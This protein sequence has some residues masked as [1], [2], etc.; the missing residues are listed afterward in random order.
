MSLQD[1]LLDL[2][3]AIGADVKA[4]KTMF[5]SPVAGL[6]G[7]LVP[8]TNAI[9]HTGGAFGTNTISFCLFDVGPVA[10]TYDALACN[11]SSTASTGTGVSYRGGVYYD[12]GTNGKP[13]ALLVDA[14]EFGVSN[15][16]I[17]V[18]TTG[19]PITLQPGRYWLGFKSSH[20]TAP[21]PVPQAFQ[22]ASAV[23]LPS[24]G[25]ATA[26]TSGYKGWTGS[27]ITTGAMPS[28][29]PTIVKATSSIAS[30]ALRV[31]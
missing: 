6:S 25:N 12:N 17:R 1:R 20:T 30:L 4:V 13:G 18:A 21:S 23:N 11:V 5:P 22:I 15:T 28:S 19:F 27:G 2:I 14:G 9:S 16:G 3:A 29:A 7:D 26:W 10:V 24:N 8:A 31:A